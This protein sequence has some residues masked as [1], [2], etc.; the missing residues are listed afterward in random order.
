LPQPHMYGTVSDLYDENFSITWDHN[1][2]TNLWG[3][4]DDSICLLQDNVKQ[5]HS[6]GCS[7]LNKREVFTGT[8]GGGEYY[9]YCPDCKEEV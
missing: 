4:T 9:W 3:I 2:I 1:G 5:Q 8:A 7:H 6:C